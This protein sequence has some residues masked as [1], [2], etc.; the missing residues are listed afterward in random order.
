M[1][2][3]EEKYRVTQ[4]HFALMSTMY[5]HNVYTYVYIDLKF[6]FHNFIFLCKN[7]LVCPLVSCLRNLRRRRAIRIFI[8]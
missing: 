1:R 4:Q 2:E 7:E 3:E 6:F 5:V 8:F